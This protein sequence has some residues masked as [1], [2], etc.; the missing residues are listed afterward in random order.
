MLGDNI[1]NIRKSRKMSINKLSE[2]S[3]VSLGYLS[4]LE[5]NNSTNPTMDKISAI[6]AALDVSESE[7]LTAEEKLEITLQALNNINKIVTDGLND[8]NDNSS[9]KEESSV[10]STLSNKLSRINKSIEESKIETLAAHFVDKEFTDNDID[11][12]ENFI[13]FILSKKEK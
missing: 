13:N 5:N 7:L 8:A 6:A 3:G 10:Y 9:V 12:I 11:D 2:I 1:R 4:D